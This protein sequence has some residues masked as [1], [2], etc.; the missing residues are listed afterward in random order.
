[1]QSEASN[2][3]SRTWNGLRLPRG[4]F[5]RS[6]TLYIRFGIGGG[7]IKVL[8]ASKCRP[9]MT[10]ARALSNA[11]ALL[12]R[13]KSEVKEGKLFTKK[14]RVS[15]ETIAADALRYSKIHKQPSYENDE[16]RMKVL[17]ALFKGRMAGDITSHEIKEA[18][19][20]K[21]A[22]RH[23]AKATFNQY[24]ML[25]LMT[26]GLAVDA[27]KVDVNPVLAVKPYKENELNNTRVRCL[28]EDEEKRI[29]T[30][31]AREYP[32][33]VCEFN[34]LY[35]TGLRHCDV[36]GR[37]GKYYQTAGLDWTDVD[38]AGRM[39]T[40]PLDKNGNAKHVPVSDEAASALR[41]LGERSGYKG[42]VMVDSEGKPR[43][44]MGKWYWRTLRLAGVSN[45]GRHDLRHNLGSILVN[46][47]VPIME[48]QKV[49]GHA[50]LK[51][52]MRYSHLENTTAVGAANILGKL[53]PS[54]STS[55]DTKTDTKTQGGLH[56]A[57]KKQVA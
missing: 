13:C 42:R 36:Y 35:Y 23:W 22:E 19:E 47:H 48:V 57:E 53:R 49:L 24:R 34:L 16:Q 45:F 29:R 38:L 33:H 15:F 18:L 28:T 43:R 8:S 37:H 14:K 39:I 46:A 41:T 7:K 50:A 55:T 21:E 51:S 20:T 12:G 32:E 5:E 25:L 4:V 27:G 54:G 6:G 17:K 1:M 11:V 44:T 2:Q 40:V 52:T 30:T 26:Y 56:V 3:K 9:G 31:L 10:P